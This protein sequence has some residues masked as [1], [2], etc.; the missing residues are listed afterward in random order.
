VAFRAP[1]VHARARHQD[2]VDNGEA[3]LAVDPVP[4]AV[5]DARVVEDGC[6]V[7]QHAA[8]VYRPGERHL[9]RVKEVKT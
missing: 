4:I 2:I 5:E 7:E 9:L 8:A 3:A 1:V 6:L